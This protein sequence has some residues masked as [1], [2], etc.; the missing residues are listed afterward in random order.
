MPFVGDPHWRLMDYDAS[1]RDGDRVVTVR[2]SWNANA[3]ANDTANDTA[4]AN[5]NDSGRSFTAMVDGVPHPIDD[6]EDLVG[7]APHGA[8]VSIERGGVTISCQRDGTEL[9]ARASAVVD[10]R[11]LT[12]P[13]RT[14]IESALHDLGEVEPSRTAPRV[15][16]FCTH[17]DYEPNTGFGGGHLACFV[18]SDHKYSAIATSDSSWTRKYEPWSAKQDLS[19][20][21]VDELGTCTLWKRRPTQHGYRG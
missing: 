18:A 15:C 4:N 6:E 13:T 17:S 7:L 3:N 9:Q 10:G 11:Q 19:Y 21:W 14:S 16:F 5:D 2:V 12:G 1:W 20:R 8:V